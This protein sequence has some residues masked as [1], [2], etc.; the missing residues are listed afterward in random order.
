MESEKFNEESASV[1]TSQDGSSNNVYHK[2]AVAVAQLLE[3][4]R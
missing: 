2:T 3:D 4:N 1:N